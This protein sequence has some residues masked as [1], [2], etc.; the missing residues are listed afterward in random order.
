MKNLR[1]IFIWALA[2]CTKVEVT[3]KYPTVDQPNHE[4]E[5]QY[6]E[7]TI[8]GGGGKGVLCRKKG[9]PSVEVLDF[10]EAKH[11][12]GL[13]INEAAST[14]DEALDLFAE[15][16]TKH[17]WNPSTVNLAEYKSGFRSRIA[18]L[19]PKTF[20]GPEKKLKLTRDSFEPLVEVDCEMVQIAVYHDESILIVDRNLWDQM[21][22]TNKVG[23]LAHE[24]LYLMDRHSGA[25]NSV[26]TRKL[27]G[28]LFSKKG[29]RPK[30]DGVPESEDKYTTCDVTDK[31]VSVGYFYAYDSRL[32]TESDEPRSGLEFVFNYLKNDSVLFR[33]SAF[34]VD[35]SLQDIL[36]E[37]FSRSVDSQV[38]IDGYIPRRFAK[39][40]FTGKGD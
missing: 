19:M 7:G 18:E 32:E 15:L 2:S 40:R 26:T 21:N 11:L 16:I 25:T 14:E 9:K 5:Y 8:N 13:E 4:S 30:A 17:L 28:Q 33:T 1:I 12:Y 39:F 38:K 3:N 20:I 36:K 10:Y 35:V 34:L 27:V 31:G 6:A 22:P 24:L 23:L 37:N 29:A